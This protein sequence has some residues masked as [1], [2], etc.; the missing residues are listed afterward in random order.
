MD[1]ITYILL[2]G[3]PYSLW[4]VRADFNACPCKVCDLADI[5][6]NDSLRCLCQP[7]GFDDSWCFREDWNIVDKDVIQL[8]SID[9]V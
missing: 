1:N 4:H 7:D 8:L 2:D 9:I 6:T 5:C 3:R